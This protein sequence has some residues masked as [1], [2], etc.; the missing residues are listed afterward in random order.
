[1]ATH[2]AL[3][4]AEYD[5]LVAERDQA[6]EAA[7][8]ATEER[9]EAKAWAVKVRGLLWDALMS[10]I[11]LGQAVDVTNTLIQRAAVLRADVEAY[12]DL[13][14]EVQRLADMY[15]GSKRYVAIGRRLRAA[16]AGHTD[17]PANPET[18]T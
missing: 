3:T 16:L 17:T 4:K 14:A 8:T 18:Q 9:D 5:D 13:R 12:R 11:P 15:E 6:L 10:P 1:V 7:R 2:V